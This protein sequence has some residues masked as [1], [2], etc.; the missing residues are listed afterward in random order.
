[1]LASTALSMPAP[2]ATSAADASS[3]A[4][5]VGTRRRLP[6]PSSASEKVTC[7]SSSGA[8]IA[9]ERASPT[10]FLKRAPRRSR[11]GSRVRAR[12]S[13]RGARCACVE[14]TRHR[15]AV[16]GPVGEVSTKGTTGRS[17]DS[18]TSPRYQAARCRSESRE[19]AKSS[20]R[21]RHAPATLR[22]VADA[23]GDARGTAVTLAGQSRRSARRRPSFG[24][25]PRARSPSRG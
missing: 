14:V 23:L 11:A 9:K 4:P 3:P 22:V 12:K 10:H 1:V 8:D 2:A 19:S 7:F 21:A 16:S 17:A 5:P 15:P 18:P 24:R 20:G 6:T 25:T 13:S